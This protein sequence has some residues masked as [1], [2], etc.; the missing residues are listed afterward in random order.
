MAGVIAFKNIDYRTA[1][2][3]NC[4]RELEEYWLGSGCSTVGCELLWVANLRDVAA[5]EFL[6]VGRQRQL[7][8]VHL[9]WRFSG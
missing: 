1:Y 8:Q 3:N 6:P 4:A 9:P 7:Q 5:F 2:L